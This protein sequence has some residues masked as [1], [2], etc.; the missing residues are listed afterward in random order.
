MLCLVRV[1]SQHELLKGCGRGGKQDSLREDHTSRF[2]S[3]W[4]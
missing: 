2:M 4:V 1:L 3:S